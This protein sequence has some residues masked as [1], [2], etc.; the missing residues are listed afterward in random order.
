MFRWGFGGNTRHDIGLRG[1]LEMTGTNT[2]WPRI[3]EAY[4]LSRSTIEYSDMAVKVKK[5]LNLSP[6]FPVTLAI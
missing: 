1:E 6:C 4:L 2:T 5:V 3:D